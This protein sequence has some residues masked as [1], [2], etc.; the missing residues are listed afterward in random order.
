MCLAI[1]RNLIL[2]GDQKKKRRQ[3]RRRKEKKKTVDFG[4]TAV[5]FA[6]TGRAFRVIRLKMFCL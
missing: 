1:G 2:S 4:K 3:R 5:A 6:C